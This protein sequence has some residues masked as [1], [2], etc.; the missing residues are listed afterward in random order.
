MKTSSIQTMES[1]S[2]NRP[3]RGD[4]NRF[5]C[6]AAARRDTTRRPGAFTGTMNQRCR[7]LPAGMSFLVEISRSSAKGVLVCI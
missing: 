1:S 6:R 2:S 7:P 5:L 4:R 3:L